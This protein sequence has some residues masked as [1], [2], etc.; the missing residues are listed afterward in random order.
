MHNMYGV[1]YMPGPAYLAG[2]YKRMGDWI[3]HLNLCRIIGKYLRTSE[4]KRP[5]SLNE[6]RNLRTIDGM[7]QSL[8]KL[9]GRTAIR[10][11][12]DCLSHYQNAIERYNDAIQLHSE[13]PAY[14]H[15]LNNMIYLEDDYGD[16]L[17]HFGAAI[18]RQMINSG[19]IR[20]R[21]VALEEEMKI[22]RLFDA[23]NYYSPV[24]QQ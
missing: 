13:G 8:E 12:D 5:L 17:N 11:I 24:S 9:V 1:K 21:I 4:V 3:K 2:F 7:E 14:K 23:D 6:K 20:R 19:K 22:S 18:E 10:H 15:Q 16:N